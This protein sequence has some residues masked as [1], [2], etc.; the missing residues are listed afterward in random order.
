M[1]VTVLE[2]QTKASKQ[3]LD[4]LYEQNLVLVTAF[5]VIGLLLTALLNPLTAELV[6]L[7]LQASL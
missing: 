4:A 6:N 7:P 1:T 5:A 3:F 2:Q